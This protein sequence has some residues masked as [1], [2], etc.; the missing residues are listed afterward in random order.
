M[1]VIVGL[2]CLTCQFQ[3]YF[4]YIVAAVIVWFFE[5]S[6]H[7]VHVW[8][9]FT[10]NYFEFDSS[11]DVINTTLFDS[12]LMTCERCWFCSGFFSLEI[13]IYPYILSNLY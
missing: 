6:I 4:S 3:Q 8:S 12:L 11:G 13:C 2:W 7:T 1:A 9:Q 5:F 10:A